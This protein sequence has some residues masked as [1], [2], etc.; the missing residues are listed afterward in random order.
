M[1][2][3]VASITSDGA[4]SLRV[5]LV[6]P[7]FSEYVCELADE[8]GKAVDL[9]VG[10]DRGNAAAELSGLR[11]NALE[12]AR[13]GVF[14]FSSASF[15]M[16]LLAGLRL[17]WQVMLFRPHIIH[18]QES[19]NKLVVLAWRLL[20]PF[21]PVVLTVHDPLPHVGRDSLALKQWKARL[22]LRRAS[23]LC[24]VHGEFCS[25]ELAR[26][27]AGSVK[28]IRPI[29]HGPI[30]IPSPG[31]VHAPQPN[32]MLFFGRM[33]KYKGI[34][35]LIEACTLLEARGVDFRLT[36]A[37]R[38]PELGR[39]QARLASLRSVE[40]LSH[41]LAPE[42]AIAQF[43]DAAVVLLPYLEATQSGVLSAA[44]ANGRGVIAS[45]VGGLPEV[46]E[47]S[48]AG[49]LVP[50]G[51]AAALADAMASCLMSRDQIAQFQSAACGFCRDVMHWRGVASETLAGYRDVIGKGG[52]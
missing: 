26:E 28:L 24:F 21:A 19:G 35:T 50:P 14:W 34:E 15:A 8:L 29:Y 13:F 27:Q 17:V 32:K 25:S 22:R 7:H 4:R 23:R 40:V 20:R 3:E 11:L 16:R 12:K 10:L 37:G 31:E 49:I 44:L 6:A 38:G 30:M 5:M 2:S 43:Q 45:A 41:W 39:L 51:D 33:E 48:G 47:A 1:A 9:L 42:A 52:R 36:I 46:V 18:V